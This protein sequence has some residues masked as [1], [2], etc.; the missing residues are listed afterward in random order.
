MLKSAWLGPT[1]WVAMC[2]HDRIRHATFAIVDDAM[3][4]RAGFCPGGDA[5][6]SIAATTNGEAEKTRESKPDAT[7]N[8][9]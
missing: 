8:A 3:V 5:A 7:T 9:M 4:L 1:L 2:W 6:R